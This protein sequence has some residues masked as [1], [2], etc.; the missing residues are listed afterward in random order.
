MSASSTSYPPSPFLTLP[1]NERHKI[2]FTYLCAY[3]HILSALSWNDLTCISVVYKLSIEN[4]G[5]RRLLCWNIHMQLKKKRHVPIPH[6]SETY[7]IKMSLH[8]AKHIFPTPDIASYWSSWIIL[9]K[10]NM[11]ITYVLRLQ[12]LLNN[13]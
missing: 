12:W 10:I 2:K 8:L 5:I 6:S 9:Y 3:K 13:M 4:F 7:N 1:F 11:I